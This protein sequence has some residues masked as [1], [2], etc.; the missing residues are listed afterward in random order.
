MFYRVEDSSIQT[1]FKQVRERLRVALEKVSDLEEA[2]ARSK[3]ECNQYK[4]KAER[5]TPIENNVD[6]SKTNK[7]LAAT[8]GSS[9]A[10]AEAARVAELRDGMERQSSELQAARSTMAELSSKVREL[11]ES[12][13]TAQ[14]EAA[15]LSQENSRLA[16]DLKEN[17]AQK[18]DQE[19]RISTLEKRYLHAQRE[20]T[21]L[22]DLNEK[23]EQELANKAA[24]LKLDMYNADAV[25]IQAAADRQGT[26]EDRLQRLEQQLEEKSTE[27]VRSRQRERMNEE[28]N[29]RLSATVDKL[30]AESNERLQLHLKERMHALDEKNSLGQ[31]LERTKRTL[32]DI[33]GERDKILTE[34]SKMRSEMDSLRH[35]LQSYRAETLVAARTLPTTSLSPVWSPSG[36]GLISPSGGAKA[37]SPVVRGPRLGEMEVA[38]P[39][40]A[41]KGPSAWDHHVLAN[42]QQAFDVTSDTECSQTDDN[43]SIFNML[44][45]SGHTDA[46]ALAYMLQEQLDAINNEIRM[47]QEEKQTTEQR[48]E[49]LESRVGSLETMGLLGPPR[50]PGGPRSTLEPP[51]GSPPQS[52]RSTPKS[53]SHHSPQH[54]DYHHKYHTVSCLLCVPFSIFHHSH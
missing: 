21:S 53:T 32:E 40:A 7:V 33:T 51:R 43:E 18:E 3:E 1:F 45:P 13:A 11:E 38:P 16:R 20:S 39:V 31:E 48:A 26:V 4:L 42:V 9:D 41:D 52:G 37:G 46:Q 35:D 19:E 34:L 28:H 49:E 17:N 24:H 29:Q 8:N 44:S 30:L 36:G 25:C 50:G 5:K 27:L 22:H 15:A 10:T 54:A 47:I 14:R 23:L 6:V 2:L 12:L